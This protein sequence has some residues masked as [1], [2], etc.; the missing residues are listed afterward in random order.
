[1]YASGATAGQSRLVWKDRTGKALG[2]LGEPTGF[3]RDIQLSPD[4][5]L[6]AATVQGRAPGTDDLWI[7]DTARGIPTRFTFDPEDRGAVWSPTIR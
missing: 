1:V 6:L 3:T 2:N 7:Y 4:G 5:K